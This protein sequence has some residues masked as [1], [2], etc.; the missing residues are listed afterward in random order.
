MI[1]EVFLIKIMEYTVSKDNSESTTYLITNTQIQINGEEIKDDL[2]NKISKIRNILISK[3][4]EIETI[5]N[6]VQSNYKGGRQKTMN[7]E[8]NEKKYR[9][10]GNTSNE[11]AAK[12]YNEITD[13]IQKIIEGVFK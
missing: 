5:S 3:A 9:I 13:K 11:E 7:I 8:F 6:S 2:R 1:N 10:I 12:L 4:K